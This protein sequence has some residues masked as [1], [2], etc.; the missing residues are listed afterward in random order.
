[1]PQTGNLAQPLADLNPGVNSFRAW[2]YRAWN[3]KAVEVAPAQACYVEF[4]S[5]SGN[6]QTGTRLLFGFLD[7]GAIPIMQV[8]GVSTFTQLLQKV[9]GP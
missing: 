3:D 6:N 2:L 8:Y 4:E 5:W 1:M 7:T 9:F